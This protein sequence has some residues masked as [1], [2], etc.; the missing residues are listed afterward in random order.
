MFFFRLNKITIFHNR[1][2]RKILGLFG[3]RR[4][5]EI[6]ILSF[7]TT[8]FTE[9]PNL[10]A[11]NQT[12]DA[13]AQKK[14]IEQAVASVVGSR[15]LTTVEN[16]SSNQ[17]LTFGDT[18][19]VVYQ[20]E[21]IPEHLDWLLLVLEDDSD[22]RDNAK[23]V[24]A[25]VG[26]HEFGDLSNNLVGAL[27]KGALANP[28]F[29][30]ASEIGKFAVNLLTEKGSKNKDDQVG[31]MYLSLNRPEHYPFGERKKDDV[32]DLTGNMLVDYSLFGV[33]M[34]GDSGRKKASRKKAK[35]V[36][37]VGPT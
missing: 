18:G 31:L 22:V 36:D 25:I 29:T 7:V 8:E 13:A 26:H 6:R 23:M 24:E 5:A 21:K 33:D 15:Q 12:T 17:K 19:Y 14:I 37:E 28:A 3:K 4:K 9:L 20:S 10:S 34:T 2:A 35:P 32:A 30:V 11:L 27:T 1:E 16:V